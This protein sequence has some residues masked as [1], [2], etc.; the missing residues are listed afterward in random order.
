MPRPYTMEFLQGVA[1][2]DDEN[3]GIRLAKAC[4][5]ANIPAKYVGEALG[6][7]R[8]TIH[9]WYRGG[10]IREKKLPLVEALI[11]L[12]EK[13]TKAGRLPAWNLETS[14]EYIR[15]IIS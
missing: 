1:A 12:I 9:T 15:S 2:S 6:V 3:T 4:I 10:K 5:E 13:D 11:R 8:M 14:K 7:S